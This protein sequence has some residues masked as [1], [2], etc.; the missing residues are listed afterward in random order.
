M[1]DEALV[2]LVLA[3]SADEGSADREMAGTAAGR[4]ARLHYETDDD[5]RNVSLTN[6]GARAA[7]R[8]LGGIDLYAA[9]QLDTL[10]RLNVALHAH[11]LLER[12]VDYIVR[13]GKVHLISASRGRVAQLQRWPD[14]LQAA[15]EAKE[16]LAATESG[17]ILDSITIQA[18]IQR[19]PRVCG[20]TGA[21]GTRPARQTPRHP[22]P[23][24]RGPA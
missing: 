18:L 10:T 24:G 19:Y 15:V 13:D 8:A 23:P 12:D 7:E 6:A 4:R 11:A 2:P 3:G 16:A 17:E 21:P 5:G 9:D 1:I 22:D 20:M 14:G